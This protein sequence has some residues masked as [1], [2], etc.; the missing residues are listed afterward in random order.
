[1]TEDALL[2]AFFALYLSTPERLSWSTDLSET[3][4]S[5]FNP[6]FV[7]RPPPC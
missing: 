1:M 7:W 3:F 2:K 5:F 6:L 4:Q